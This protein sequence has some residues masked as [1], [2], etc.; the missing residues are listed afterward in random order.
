MAT[1]STFTQPLEI[2]IRRSFSAEFRRKKVE[3]IDCKISTVSEISREYQVTRAAVYKW[4]K[5]YSST[6]KK[7]DRLIVE[8]ESDTR[9]LATLQQRIAELE[10]LLGQKQIQLEFM[11]K[12]IDIAE[13]TYQVDI[14]KKFGGKA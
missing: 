12:I 11:E 14:K 9:K 8:A 3:E 2:R 7:K 13:E 10:R 1:R 5:Q 6:M 4:L